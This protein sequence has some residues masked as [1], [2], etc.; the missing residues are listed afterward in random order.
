[1]YLELCV[2][3]VRRGDWGDEADGY[4]A[5]WF[6]SHQLLHMTTE[7]W[8][9]GLLERGLLERGLLGQVVAVRDGWS[10]CLSTVPWCWLFL[11]DAGYQN[12]LWVLSLSSYSYDKHEVST[13]VVVLIF[14]DTMEGSIVSSCCSTNPANQLGP[15][16]STY[17]NMAWTVVSST[18]IWPLS[19]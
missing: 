4:T 10:F 1:M 5:S 16:I 8:E 18:L 6:W 9:R 11:A 12:V 3:P 17:L 7:R 19:I 2:F 14:S 15:F 13:D